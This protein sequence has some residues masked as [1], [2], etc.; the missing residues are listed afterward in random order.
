M[1]VSKELQEKIDKATRELELLQAQAAEETRKAAQEA[2][3]TIKKL[4]KE[5]EL[6]AQDL[7]F[8]IPTAKSGA[9]PS[10]QKAKYAMGD[11]LWSGRGRKPKCIEEHLQQGGKLEDLL[12]K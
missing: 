6:T 1:A 7:G 11:K 3:D 8:S 5:H 4:I 9:K 10:V 12:I 2:I